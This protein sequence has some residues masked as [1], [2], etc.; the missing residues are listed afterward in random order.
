[1]RHEISLDGFIITSDNSA[2]IG[3]KQQDV[4]QAPDSITAK[5]AARVALLEQWA[6]GSQPQAVLLHNFSGAAHWD[7]YRAGV[8]DLFAEAETHLP[9]ISGSTETNMA[10]LQSGIAVTMIGKQSRKQAAAESLNWFVYGIPLVGEDV[11]KKADGIADLAAIKK[12]L[13]SELIERVWPVGSKGIAHEVELLMGKSMEFSADL[14]V[15]SSAGP[16]TCVL[17]GVLPAKREHLKVY[18]GEHLFSIEFQ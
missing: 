10:T 2:A 14:D 11:L 12:A 17:V 18:F 15:D 1:M 8:A 16:A 7:A 9:P 3:E 13:E 5:F 6:S 4:V